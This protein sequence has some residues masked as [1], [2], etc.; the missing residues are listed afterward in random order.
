MAKKAGS[1]KKTIK[2]RKRASLK[3]IRVRKPT[4][5]EC[6]ACGIFK[7]HSPAAIFKAAPGCNAATIRKWTA[8]LKKKR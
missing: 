7:G 4:A 2:T 1:R 3:A 5:A 8:Y 6:R